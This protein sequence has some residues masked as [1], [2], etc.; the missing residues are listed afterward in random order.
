MAIT[1]QTPQGNLGILPERVIINLPLEANSTVGP[2]EYKIISGSLPRG[3]RLFEN[4]IIGSPVEVRKFTESKFV[5]RA[6]DRKSVV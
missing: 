4:R 2:V 6:R 3:L 5:V 1:W